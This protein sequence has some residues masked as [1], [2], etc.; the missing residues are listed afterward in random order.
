MTTACAPCCAFVYELPLTKLLLGDSFHP[1]GNALTR[2]LAEQALVG[3]GTQVLDIAC[4][5]GN[6]ARLLAETFGAQV[7]GVDY[8]EKLLDTARLV[9]A[10]TAYAHRLHFV[11]GDAQHL[12]C[13]AE[14]FDVVLCECALCTFAD[15]PRALSEMLR[16]LK[17]GGR[18]ALSDITL[19]AALPSALQNSLG[20]ALCISGA[21]SARDYQALIEGSGFGTTRFWDVSQVLLETVQRIEQR[22]QLAEVISALQ[23]IEVPDTLQDVQATLDTARAFIAQGGLG[24]GLFVARK[25]RQM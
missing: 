19:N 11:Q 5:V 18:L 8:S 4:G 24:Y 2:Q 16:V 10:E 15:A 20:L 7:T 9:S 12:P 22:L 6:S 3:P 14:Q 21:R 25:P 13:A 1:G 23:Q 17:P